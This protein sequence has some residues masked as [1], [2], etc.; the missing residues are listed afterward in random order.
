MRIL[1]VLLV[2][3]GRVQELYVYEINER[4]RQSPAYLRLSQ[5][6]TNALGDLV[7]FTNKVSKLSDLF[8]SSFLRFD[9]ESSSS[10]FVHSCFFWKIFYRKTEQYA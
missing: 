1:I 7:P 4:D 9:F 6:N 2:S 3:I 5:K 10:M 8:I